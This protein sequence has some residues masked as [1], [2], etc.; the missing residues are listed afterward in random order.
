M[1]ASRIVILSFLIITTGACVST[2]T[3]AVSRAESGPYLWY[4]QPARDWNEALPVGNGTLGA[5][6]F[7]GVEE[8]R[9][10]IN[11]HELWAGGPKDRVNPKG[12]VALPEVRKLIFEGK[13]EEATKLAESTMAG[14]PPTIE[15]Y[16][17]LC[18]LILKMPGEKNIT[19]YRRELRLADGVSVT[20]WKRAD[21]TRIKR[22]VFVSY[23]DRVLVARIES[24]S[25]SPLDLNIQLR[26]ERDAT[27]KHLDDGFISLRGNCNKGA[28]ME[29][30]ALAR[31]AAP[32]GL[33]HSR[34]GGF[35]VEGARSINILLASATSLKYQHPNTVALDAL[36]KAVKKD[37][38][39]LLAAHIND[40]RALFDRVS[41]Q[42]GDAHDSNDKI[43]TDVRLANYKKGAPDH[44]LESLLFQYGRYLLIG[45]SR[46]GGLPAN[47]QGLWC[48][49][50]EAPWDSDYH[51]NINV[52]MNYWLAET[53]NL[54]ELHEPLIDFMEK[55]KPHGE[56]VAKRL[57]GARGWTAHHITDVF[58]FAVPADGVWGIWPMGAAWLAQH[59]WEHYAFSNN[60]EYLAARAWPL[61]KGASE[62]MLDFLIEA[63]AGSPAAGRL[64][65][66]PSHS[67]ENWYK[68]AGGASASLTYAATMDLQIIDDLFTNTIEASHLLNIESEFRARLKSARLQLAPLQI[69]KKTGALQEWI[70]DYEESEP[71]HRHVSHMFGLHPGRQITA[72]GTPELANA[73]RK[74]LER[75]GDGGTGWSKAWKINAWARL[76]DGDHAYKML[77]ELL[78][79]S[80]LNNLFDNH[81]P[82]QIDG[83][84]GA[85]AGVAEMLLQSHDGAIELLPAL[86]S[87]WPDGRVR[88]LRARGGFVVDI[89][90]RAGAASIVTITPRISGRAGVRAPRGQRIEAVHEV[91]RNI[92]RNITIG[93]TP[94]GSQQFHAAAGREYRLTFRKD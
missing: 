1:I 86:P 63:P 57:Y 14:I 76:H 30:A 59:A 65:T 85:T 94:G 38:E 92:T 29:F 72:R 7:G 34:E 73:I 23:P 49:D 61:L 83:N 71:Q 3:S 21:G 39:Y 12:I 45:S 50:Y 19:D 8:E 40:N 5:M 25:G 4:S 16:E 89:E 55:L 84:F 64:V 6:V 27:I 58:G 20:S 42:I 48:K 66:N 11:D 51:L 13:T 24:E 2:R 56:D 75:R 15:S 88:G 46:P 22:S 43:P 69:S 78:K 77:G 67:P 35:A 41:L 62:F 10:Q 54:A 26:R 90:W 37:Y 33:L 81:P 82:F 36:A 60:K 93:D 53:C 79:H 32:G 44:A 47:L 9:L 52:Q 17:P 74:T 87:A 18:D 70:E 80:I 28:G 91:N 68:T 31:V